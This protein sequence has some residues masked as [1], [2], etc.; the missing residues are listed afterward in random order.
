MVVGT[1]TLRIPYSADDRAAAVGL[2]G[3]QPIRADQTRRLELAQLT[4][5]VQ[6][7]GQHLTPGAVAA[8]ATR[9]RLAARVHAAAAR[10]EASEAL[11]VHLEEH[12]GTLPGHVLAR[13]RPDSVWVRLHR[14]GWVKRL[15]EEGDPVTLVVAACAV[16]EQLPNGVGRVDR[17]MLVPGNP[18]ALDEGQPLAGL[19]LALADVGSVRSRSGWDGLGVDCD[20]IVGGLI[21]LGLRP[22]GWSMPP[23]AVVTIPPRELARVRWQPPPSPGDWAFVT[24]NPSI[25]AAASD[26]AAAGGGPGRGGAVHLLC[27]AG[28]PSAVETTAVGALS[29]AGWRVAVRAD[30]DTAGL[31]H[32]RALLGAAPGR[33]PGGWTPP[34]TSRAT[35]EVPDCPS[36]RAPRRGIRRWLRR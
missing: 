9:R 20:D 23:H 1:V 3:G 29:D 33:R 27:T 13:V 14:S 24:E 25:L 15:L 18:H 10:A 16:L 19:V 26:V 12:L 7:R 31:A 4:Q 30:F 17:R 11:R 6:I 8:H 28:T 5:R 35:P 32:V 36:M 34:I 22:V 21:V 2:L